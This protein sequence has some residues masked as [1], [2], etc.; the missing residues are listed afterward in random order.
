MRTLTTTALLATALFCASAAQAL[1][2]ADIKCIVVEEAHNSTV[3]PALALAV[4]KVESNFDDNASSHKGARGVMQIMPATARGVF[5]ADPDDLWDARLNVQMGIAFLERLHSQYGNKWDRA[6]SHYNGGPLKGGAGPDAVPHSYTAKYV[7]KVKLWWERYANHCK[8]CRVA[9][10]PAVGTYSLRPGEVFRDC[11]DCP[12][13][14]VV[15]SGSFMMGSPESEE[16]R[17]KDEGPRYCVRIPAPFA[18]GRFEVTFSEWDACVSDGGCGGY[19]PK[20]R[21]WGRDRRPVIYVSWNDAKRYVSWLSKKTGRGYR[22]L[23]EAEWEYV[24]R[25]G[26]TTRYHWGDDYRSDRVAVGGKTEA[27]GRYTSNRFGLHDVH[28]NV[29][30]WVEDCWN[31]SY[32]GAPAHGRPW[33]MGDCDTRMV[34]GGSWQDKPSALRA[35]TRGSDKVELRIETAGFR[36]ARTL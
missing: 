23:S 6:L 29:W 3:P 33:V 34:R 22:L 17:D 25:A 27:V 28:G 15:P 21:D 10:T 8:V 20:D 14:V 31:G 2:R 16:G 5:G 35:A 13:M 1:T 30:E 18:V 32:A 19:R 11:A 12:E 24:A 36:V 4:A 9:A 7:A 26:T